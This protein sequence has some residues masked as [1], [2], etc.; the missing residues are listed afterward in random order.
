MRWM[1]PE[2][3]LTADPA[4]VALSRARL[5]LLF[6]PQLCLGRDPL[7]VLEA[8]LPHV[9]A[10]QVRPKSAGAGSAAPCGARETWEWALRVL[11][12]LRA[13]TGAP[14]VVLV[15]DRVD[16]AVALQARGVAGVH[17]GQDDLDPNAARGLLGSEALI[18]LSTHDMLQVVEGCEQPV[19][20]LGFGPVN[21]TATK[22]Y[23]LGLG[24]E[25]CWI[26]AEAATLPVFPIGGID[27]ANA[28]ELAR[29]GRAAL[30]SAILG[31]DDPGRAARELRALLAGVDEGPHLT[32]GAAS[33]PRS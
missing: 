11:D 29:V 10:L 19:D 7:A 9:D 13:R 5:M 3:C 8:A 15:D 33:R 16:V 1:H 30:S 24:T 21:A 2:R 12:L 6:S 28:Q 20:Y 17:L 14:L 26:A 31:A 22:G 18:G 32:A 23:R 27:L 4:R 25:A